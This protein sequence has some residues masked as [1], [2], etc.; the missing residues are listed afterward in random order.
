MAVGVTLVTTI[1]VLTLVL[2]AGIIVLAVLMARKNSENAGTAVGSSTGSP[3]KWSSDQKA[4]INRALLKN[5]KIAGGDNFKP[6]LS[7]DTVA[8]YLD[9]WPKLKKEFITVVGCLIQSL[10][11]KY[12]HSYVN[13]QL[14]K[15]TIDVGF[16]RDLE[17]F[18]EPCGVNSTVKKLVSGL[19]AVA[20]GCKS[21]DKYK[22]CIDMVR[23]SDK[24]SAL[25][26][27]EADAVATCFSDNCGSGKSSEY[28]IPI[29]KREGSPKQWKD[30][31]RKI[32]K[33]SLISVLWHGLK[34]NIKGA[35]D[36]RIHGEISKVADCMVD[37]LSARQSY[38]V[39]ANNITNIR[40]DELAR[41]YECLGPYDVY[42]RDHNSYT[43]LEQDCGYNRVL[44]L[45]DY[46]SQ[47]LHNCT[48]YYQPSY[49][50][51]CSMNQ[52]K[53]YTDCM[54]QNFPRKMNTNAAENVNWKCTRKNCAGCAKP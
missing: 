39:V 45:A 9:S 7:G 32:I 27:S 18:S 41:M 20:K 43:G 44:I 23:F 37:N 38:D 1:V 30:C 50:A 21:V 17:T 11:K 35:V 26:N 2:I 12:S 46:I 52:A 16:K 22:S 28:Q 24:S 33:E 31:Q 29:I 10:S 3:G 8:K 40:Y 48:N 25:S 5:I 13:Q 47:F 34:R 42:Q 6:S 4:T 15:A 14:S 53:S 49:D 51:E 54:F 36:S 19:R